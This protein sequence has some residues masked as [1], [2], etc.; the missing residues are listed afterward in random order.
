MQLVSRG[1]GIQIHLLMLSHSVVSDSLQTR[2]LQHTISNTLF[3]LFV[4][5]F[6]A[7][8]CGMRDL[9]SLTRDGTRAS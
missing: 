6:V 2:G 3:S 8:L 1:T 5:Y 7:T 4:S 9:S